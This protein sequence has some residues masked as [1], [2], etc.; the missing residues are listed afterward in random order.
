MANKCVITGKGTATGNHVSHANNKVK[1]KFKSNLKKK[2]YWVA[3][4]SKYITITV[5]TKGIRMIDKHGIDHYIN[6]IS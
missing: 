3:S 4:M 2:R 1:R 6:E 5:S